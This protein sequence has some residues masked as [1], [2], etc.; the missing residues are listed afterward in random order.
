M[1]RLHIRQMGRSISNAINPQA[2]KRRAPKPLIETETEDA[3]ER[4]INPIYKYY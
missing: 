1:M 3:G 2:D 4:S